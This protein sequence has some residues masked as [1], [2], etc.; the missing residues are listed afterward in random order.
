[1]VRWIWCLLV[2]VVFLF[3]PALPSASAADAGQE[4]GTQ[5]VAK[6]GGKGKKG[7]R[8][9]GRKGKKG[10]KGGKGKRGGKGKKPAAA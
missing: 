8:G 7:K 9:K 1:M 4:D 5:L 3:G 2:A 10:K 6:K